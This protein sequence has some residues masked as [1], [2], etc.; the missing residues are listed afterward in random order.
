MDILMFHNEQ[1]L[2]QFWDPMALYYNQFEI[3]LQNPR[4]TLNFSTKQQQK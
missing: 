3:P 1:H 2:T 4:E